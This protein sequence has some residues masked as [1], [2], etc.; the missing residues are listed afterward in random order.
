MKARLIKISV[1]V[2]LLSSLI[3]PQVL[4]G[5]AGNQVLAQEQTETLRP[6]EPGDQCGIYGQ[7][8]ASCPNHYLNVDDVTPDE[9]AT[10][11]RQ[12]TVTTSSGTDLYNIPDTSVGSGVINDVTVRARC[13]RQGGMAYAI[14]FW[15]VLKTHDTVYSQRFRYL[16]ESYSDLSYT[17]TNNPFTGQ[18]W[19]WNEINDLQIG[20]TLEQYWGV[21]WASSGICTQVY[22]VVDYTP[23]PS[24]EPPVADFYWAAELMPPAPSENITFDASNSYDTDSLIVSYDWSFSDGATGENVTATHAY[25]NAGDYNVT[26]TVTDNEGATDTF[27]KKVSVRD[28]V[29]EIL[30]PDAPGDKCGYPW[31]CTS[32]PNHWQCV[33]DEIPDGGATQVYSTSVPM[34]YMLS[35]LYNT[36][37]HTAGE[38]T[39]RE[40]TVYGRFKRSSKDK[41]GRPYTPYSSARVGIETGGVEYTSGRFMVGTSWD[42][43]GTTWATNPQTGTPWTWADIDALQIGTAMGRP[44]PRGIGLYTYCTQNWVEVEYAPYAVGAVFE[45]TPGNPE[46]GTN[47]TFNASSSFPSGQIES[48]EWDFGDNT[49]GENVTVTHAYQNAGDHT[50]TL[51]V[52]DSGG[53]TASTSKVVNVWHWSLFEAYAP[54]LYLYQGLWGEEL[55]RP[56]ETSSMLDSSNL[57]ELIWTVQTIKQGPISKSDLEEY[58]NDSYYLDMWDAQPNV[59]WGLP[60]PGRFEEYLITVYGRE[61]VDPN[62][63]YIVLQYWFFYPYNDWWLSYHEGDW[64]MITIF[65]DKPAEPHE[66]PQ[67]V[68]LACAQHMFGTPYDWEDVQKVGSGQTNSRVF[69]AKG[70]HASY[71]DLG[72]HPIPDFISD[73]GVA[74]YPNNVHPGEVTGVVDKKLYNLLMIGSLDIQVEWQGHW[75][76]FFPGFSGPESPGQQGDK[77]SDPI[78]W[79][80][81]IPESVISASVGSPVNLHAY[82]QYGNHVGLNETGEIEL[83]IPVTYIY[84]PSEEEEEVIIIYTEE[85][86]RF[87]IEATGAGQFDFDLGRYIKSEDKE[88]VAV[89]ENVLITENTTATLE[90]S[91]DNPQYIME[92]DADGDGTVDEYKPPDYSIGINEPPVADAN[93]PYVG[94]E[95]SPITFTAANSTDPDSDPLQYRWDFDGDGAWDTVWLLEATVNYTW[96][97]DYSGSVTL[98]VSDGEFIASDNTSVIVNNAAPIAEAGP[99]QTVEVFDLVSFNGSSSDPGWL[100]THTFEWDFGDNNT[101]SGQNVSH[102]Y[103]STGNYTVTFTVTDD[104]GGTGVDT[105]QVSVKQ[106][107]R[108]WANSTSH[109]EAID[110]SGSNINVTGKVHSN[111]GIKVSGSVNTVNGTTAY[112]S[113]FNDSGSDNSY[114]PPPAQDEVRSFPV[115]YNL[116]DYQPGGSEALAAQAEGKYHNIDGDLEVSDSGVVLNGLYYVTGEVKLSGS[117]ISGQ[118]TIIAE[119]DIS[120]DISGSEFDCRAY[121]GDLLFLCNGSLLKMAGSNSYFEGVVYVPNGVIE[122]S[123]SENTING[124]LFG[125]TIKLSGSYVNITAE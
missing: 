66:T 90:V 72:L 68:T 32:C 55:F 115:Q 28:P 2:I 35:E 50:V 18:P 21:G 44:A 48:Y 111:D 4:L 109:T 19:N 42:N 97:D 1:I 75:G 13:R 43:Y 29:I 82:D 53:L 57:T 24:N 114:T 5:P 70:S 26:L 52:T 94:E 101:A 25:Q 33:D 37:N 31:G 85:D 36:E 30:R 118:F 84:R 123:G 69:V 20:V 45:Y 64:E 102:E 120:Q 113:S 60:D 10:V 46:P 71:V 14:D 41:Y 106:T 39:I 76:E 112:V 116:A 12:S 104:D 8:G 81:L 95:G 86:L 40:I 125:N 3:I 54:V 93:G 56:N 17:W 77:W 63:N 117:N 22:A 59:P 15:I 103:S 51:T 6:S 89:Y 92:V 34:P 110:W 91:L 87:E 58:N 62:D 67:P 38:G 74:L 98:E 11:V 78:S 96:G 122:L 9:D 79:A 27:S 7:T 108:I 73:D 121:S 49:T 47:I 119:G 65:L 16:G 100:D 88:V 83:E 23:T 80:D 124:S 99:D 105:A 107:Y 61:Y